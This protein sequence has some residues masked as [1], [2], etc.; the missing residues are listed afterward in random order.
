MSPILE[1]SLFF[2]FALWVIPLTWAI[3][4]TVYAIPGKILA[5][6]GQIRSLIRYGRSLPELYRTQK[7]KSKL[8]NHLRH[9]DTSYAALQDS[10]VKLRDKVSI[11]I[12]EKES[13][14]NKCFKLRSELDVLTATAG[15]CSPSDAEAMHLE[16]K[17][18][19]LKAS[20]REL[21]ECCQRLSDLRDLLTEKETQ[22]QLAYTK[23][24]VAIAT[25]KAEHAS[26]E[27][28]RLLSG[29]SNLSGT[30]ARME[31]KV[32]AREADAYLKFFV[33]DRYVD[34]PSV[35]KA[36]SNLSIDRLGLEELLEILEAI[37]EAADDLHQIL[38]AGKTYGTILSMR[39]RI[40]ND[41]VET[42]TGKVEEA[43]SQG[44]SK[45]AAQAEQRRAE[46]ALEASNLETMIES[47]KICSDDFTQM[48]SDLAAKERE[49]FDRI[50]E[51]EKLKRDLE[52]AQQTGSAEGNSADK[53]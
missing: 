44:S 45:Q 52:Q 38:I 21:E 23:K 22:V 27:A 10:L 7:E 41:E 29:D 16:H 1:I 49:I 5:I 14:A 47:A 26:R 12:N 30:I 40:A 35:A 42:L 13:L 20:M 28:N 34:F 24:Q 9:L 19:S 2:V 33:E 32:L 31:Q 8:Q 48:H 46:F 51:L 3:V 37:D 11:A 50:A 18:E 17:R 4:H 43:K 39:V 53:T 15:A 25:A 6:P 36:V